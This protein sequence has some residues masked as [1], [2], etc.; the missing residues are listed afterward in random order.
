MNS[1]FARRNRVLVYS[2][3]FGATVLVITV[4]CALDDP[5]SISD[6]VSR[7]TSDLENKNYGEMRRHIHPDV[8][9]R[10]LLNSEY[11]DS[12]FGDGPFSAGSP[13]G[14]GSNRTVVVNDAGTDKDLVFGMQQDGDDWYI[15][16]LSY[17]GEQVVPH[18]NP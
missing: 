7:F 16:T 9:E 2:I 1:K 8:P 4:G 11:W 13:S 6:R 15:G 3:L 12:V 5:V 10:N 18:P 17:D 14:S